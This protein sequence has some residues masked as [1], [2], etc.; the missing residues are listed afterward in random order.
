MRCCINKQHMERWWLHPFHPRRLRFYSDSQ[1]IRTFSCF[2]CIRPCHS[3]SNNKSEQCEAHTRASLVQ[4]QLLSLSLALTLYCT[5]FMRIFDFI[6][7]SKQT[8]AP[9]WNVDVGVTANEKEA[10]FVPY[11]SDLRMHFRRKLH[12]I[13]NGNYFIAFRAVYDTKR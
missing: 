9:E 3:L 12:R 10:K 11:F 8:R 6:M 1:Q 13:S 4:K 7:I 2:D 5:L